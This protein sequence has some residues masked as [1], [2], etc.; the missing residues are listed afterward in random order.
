MV[1]VDRATPM[2]YPPDLREWV[3]DDDMVH[4]VI[5]SVDGTRLAANA[6][7]DCDARYDRAGELQEQLKSELPNG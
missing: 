1:N 4:L 2:L 6:S 3:G 5:E 7:K